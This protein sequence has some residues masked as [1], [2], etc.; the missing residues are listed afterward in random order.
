MLRRL[1]LGFVFLSFAT[2]AWAANEL[3]NRRAPGVLTA[4]SESQ[5]IRLGGLPRQGRPAQFHE[6]DCPNC[7]R[8]P[9][10]FWPRRRTKYKGRLQVLSIAPSPPETQN[11]V[12]GYLNR[13]GIN[14]VV[15]FDCR[16]VAMSYFKLSP[17][18][19]TFDV[20]HFFVIDQRGRIREDYGYNALNRGIFE[21][22]GL[23]PDYRALRLEGR[24]IER[25]IAR[26]I[27]RSRP[28]NARGLANRFPQPAARL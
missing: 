17:A 3:S 20:P 6:T 19:P 21:E 28:K 23:V 15:L 24:F 11:S 7:F 16:Q 10:R 25:R 18:N 22:E 14:Q 27:L 26:P 5:A 13:N 4:G 2:T 9:Q 8:L 12:R 1:A